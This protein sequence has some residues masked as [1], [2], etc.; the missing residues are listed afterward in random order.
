M[1]VSTAAQ[2]KYILSALGG[3]VIIQLLFGVADA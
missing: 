1:Q 2:N 3:V